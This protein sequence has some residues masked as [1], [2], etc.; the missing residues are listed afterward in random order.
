MF[1]CNISNPAP[2]VCNKQSVVVH[3]TELTSQTV[4][5]VAESSTFNN[6]QYTLGL[7]TLVNYV[8]VSLKI[9]WA[10]IIWTFYCKYMHIYLNKFFCWKINVYTLNWWRLSDCIT[11]ALAIL[12]MY[13]FIATFYYTTVQRP[14]ILFSSSEYY[15]KPGIHIETWLHSLTMLT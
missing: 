1:I 3:T 11:F 12:G 13:P 7:D 4:R 10:I 8:T 9:I 2:I 14:L 15:F 5:S 6:Y